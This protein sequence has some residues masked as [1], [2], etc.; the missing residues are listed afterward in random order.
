MEEFTKV[1]KHLYASLEKFNVPLEVKPNDISM[2]QIQTLYP[3][4]RLIDAQVDRD[5]VDDH[6]FLFTP[7][8]SEKNFFNLTENNRKILLAYVKKLYEIQQTMDLS[9]PDI[10]S[11]I[12]DMMTMFDTTDLSATD[13]D[14]QTAAETLGET[15][16]LEEN[17]PMRAVMKEIIHK[18]GAGLKS[19]KSVQDLI[20]EAT[21]SFRGRITDDLQSGTITKEQIEASQRKMMEKIEKLMRNPMAA[22]SMMKSEETKKKEKAERRKAMRKKWRKKN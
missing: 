1:Y 15:M 6:V 21:M 16:G 14:I 12:K 11:Q 9:E 18:V 19:G 7:L 8:I 5:T 4:F 10:N 17:D 3:I 20:K 13:E 2:Q 22:A